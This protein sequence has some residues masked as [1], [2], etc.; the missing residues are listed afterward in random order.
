[1][2]IAGVDA[3]LCM[4]TY[5]LLQLHTPRPGESAFDQQWPFRAGA[6]GDRPSKSWLGPQI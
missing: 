1:M 2:E 4:C 6:G 5:V 3:A